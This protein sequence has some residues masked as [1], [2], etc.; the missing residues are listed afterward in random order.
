MNNNYIHNTT[1]LH[2]LNIV[3]ETRQNAIVS[4]RSML[5]SSDVILAKTFISN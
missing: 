5:G 1:I 2:I 4:N 3:C